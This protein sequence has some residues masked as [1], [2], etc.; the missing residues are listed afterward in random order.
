[1]TKFG[2]ET[3]SIRHIGGEGRLGVGDDTLLHDDVPMMFVFFI[4][5][6]ATS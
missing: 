5:L 1:M 4:I 6:I 3:P 2:G